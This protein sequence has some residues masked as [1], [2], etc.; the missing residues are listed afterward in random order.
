MTKPIEIDELTDDLPLGL[1]VL[2]ERKTERT[3]NITTDQFVLAEMRRMVR[4]RT[5][6]V[7]HANSTERPD[8]V[9]AYRRMADHKS[10]RTAGTET[11]SA[12]TIRFAFWLPN[13][14]AQSRNRTQKSACS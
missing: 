2:P 13:S 3:W 7:E 9:L 5:E 4:V 10:A 12:R 14:N 6:P 8:G 1:Y 11:G